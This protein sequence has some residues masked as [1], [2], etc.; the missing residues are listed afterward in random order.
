MATGNW[1]SMGSGLR[2]VAFATMLA[3]GAL[4]V[5]A[6]AF[7]QQATRPA[8]SARS[9]DEV[10]G[11]VKIDLMVVYANYSGQVD[12]RLRDLQRQL[13][14]MKYTGYQILSTHDA[15]LGDGQS[16]S[17]QIEGG[18]KVEIKILSRDAEEAKVQIEMYKGSE[19]KIDTTIRIHRNRTILISGPK[20]QEGELILPISVTY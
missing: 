7:A 20:Y 12:P 2:R 1:F 5:S 8:T 14:M 13:Q 11:K 18:R 17:F 9:G 15:Q 3:L 19:K 10:A 4:S 6:D 16:T